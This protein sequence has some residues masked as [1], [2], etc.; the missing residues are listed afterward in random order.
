MDDDPAIFILETLMWFVGGAF[1][2]MSF[3]VGLC[4]AGLFL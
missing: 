2:V 3:A 4:I 1:V